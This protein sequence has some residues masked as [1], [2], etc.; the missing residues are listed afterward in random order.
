MN[1]FRKIFGILFAALFVSTAVPALIFFNFERN[2]FSAETYQKAFANADLYNKLPAA[3][4]EAMLSASTDQSRLPIVMRG[5]SQNAWEEFFRTLLP[6]ETLKTMSGDVLNST[7]AYLNR[8]TNSVELSLIPLKVSMTSGTGVQAVYT[9]LNTQPD[10]TLEQLF[11][12]TMGLLSKNEMQFCKPPSELYPLLTPV[13]QE[14][15][16]FATL[17]IPDQFILLNAPAE[18]DPR[19]RLNT[20]RMVMRLS[21]ILPLAFLLMMTIVSVNSLKSWLNWWGASFMMT[22]FLAGLMSLSGAP[23]FGTI[24]QRILVNRMPA[25]LPTL[26]LEYAGDLASAM[27]QAILTPVLWQGLVI[28]LTGTVMIIGAYFVKQNKKM[29]E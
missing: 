3:M 8:Q 2:A 23:I 17:A 27:V 10:C 29:T 18:N 13:I 7:F 16:Q 25:F 28:A 15:M 5:M 24:F 4:A 14:Q 6:Q 20:A 21:P 12:M 22:G 11:Q 1:S 26:L 19:V 9:L